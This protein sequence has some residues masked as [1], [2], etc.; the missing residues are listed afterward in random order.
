M[1]NTAQKTNKQNYP[2]LFDQIYIRKAFDKEA[3]I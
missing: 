2:K 3:F 1:D